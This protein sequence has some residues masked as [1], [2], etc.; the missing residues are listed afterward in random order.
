M[1]A[2][3]KYPEYPN[4][5]AFELPSRAIVPIYVTTHPVRNKVVLI[6]DVYGSKGGSVSR[7]G[8]VRNIN[9]IDFAY[10]RLDNEDL[11]L[12]LNNGDI[13]RV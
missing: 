10:F 6:F 13:I 11:A 9:G 3:I 1:R 12:N 8:D 4:T 2:N 7:V 5:R